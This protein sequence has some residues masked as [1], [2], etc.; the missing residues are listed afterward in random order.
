MFFSNHD[1]FFC[2]VISARSVAVLASHSRANAS[3]VWASAAGLR[4]LLVAF[5][6]C[7]ITAIRNDFSSGRAFCAG[8]E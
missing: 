2:C 1:V 3:K 8:F 4:Q 5:H 7:G 6:L